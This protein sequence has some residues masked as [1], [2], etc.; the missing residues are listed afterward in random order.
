LQMASERV[1]AARLLN[2]HSTI[3]GKGRAEESILEKAQ[4]ILATAS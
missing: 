4:R 2:R 1:S 3:F